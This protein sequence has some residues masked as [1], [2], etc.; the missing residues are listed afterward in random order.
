MAS[1]EDV[2]SIARPVLKGI[3]WNALAA[4]GVNQH[5]VSRGSIYASDYYY[6]YMRPAGLRAGTVRDTLDLDVT[7]EEAYSHFR[8][9]YDS[10]KNVSNFAYQAAV[11]Q[12]PL[13]GDD[14]AMRVGVET[15]RAGVA[16]CWF[17]ALYSA[18]LHRT[19]ALQ[20]SGKMSDED[21]VR[22]AVLT[23]AMFEC[24]TLLD[25]WGILKPIKKGVR[26]GVSA[27]P[28]VA[29]VIIA[30]VAVIAIAIIAFM[31]LSIMDV[32]EKNAIMK[33]EC[34]EA[35]ASGD[36]EVYQAC[37]EALK[38]P[39]ETIATQLYKDTIKEFAPYI[40]AIVG[41][42]VLIGLSPFIVSRLS[43]AGEVSR[44]KKRRRWEERY[45]EA[46]L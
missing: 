6:D 17:T 23:T 3:D 22:H 25:G 21:I 44:R 26:G 14:E 11:A 9:F 31:V 36:L 1:L 40:M 7:A 39:N 29:G 24:I 27:V 37:L 41:G 10:V 2:A 33:N 34:E 35:R 28:V 32:S 4:K 30:I 43:R 20:L 5:G 38:S 8:S 45:R 16:I 13:L 15:L 46:G 12:V 18:E 42:I 19:G